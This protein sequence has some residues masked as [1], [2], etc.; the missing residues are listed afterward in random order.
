M[1]QLLSDII[2]PG[3]II[4]KA[5]A[6]VLSQESD[7]SCILGYAA[8]CMSTILIA[9]KPSAFSGVGNA[10]ASITMALGY[11]ISSL[12]QTIRTQRKLDVGDEAMNT[13]NLAFATCM[14]SIAV[15]FA[16]ISLLSRGIIAKRTAS[17]TDIEKLDD[18][19]RHTFA[20]LAYRK[21][22]ALYVVFFVIAEI[23]CVALGIDA[24]IKM[25]ALDSGMDKFAGYDRAF[26]A[27]QAVFVAY[28][29]IATMSSHLRRHRWWTVGL[30]VG[31][32]VAS[33]GFMI[34]AHGYG[35]VGVN[36]GD[37]SY[38]QTFNATA[39]IAGLATTIV[40]WVTSEDSAVD[41]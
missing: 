13:Q 28:T 24:L 18:P 40:D 12:I 22:P 1:V 9:I 37:W 38:G 31:L 30:A 2:G 4:G 3:I 27:L 16:S 7:I 36:F 19:N 35:N 5:A 8:L 39:G 26:L 20:E 14:T 33:L 41:R 10:M 6:F 21:V 17:N 23:S 34:W 32:I 15:A 25:K 29:A 11:S